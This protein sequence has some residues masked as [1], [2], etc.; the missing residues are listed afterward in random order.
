MTRTTTRLAAVLLAACLVLAGCGS[1]GGGQDGRDRITFLNILP[2]ESLGY[3]AEM[4][5][6]TKGFFAAHG[7]DVTFEATQGSAPA[8]QTLLAGGL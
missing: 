8:I 1:G 7:L 4:V 3:A 2:M 6:D 5:A